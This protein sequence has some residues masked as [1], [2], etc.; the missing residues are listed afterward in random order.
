MMSSPFDLLTYSIFQLW[1]GFRLVIHCFHVC[2]ELYAA[3]DPLSV[4]YGITPAGYR[5]NRGERVRKRAPSKPE[6]SS[7]IAEKA[8]ESIDVDK[9]ENKAAHV[10][11]QS[12]EMFP[13][14]SCS[15][16]LPAVSEEADV[17]ELIARTAE[18]TDRNGLQLESTTELIIW[19]GSK[20][21]NTLGCRGWNRSDSEWE[22]RPENSSRRRDD[23]LIRCADDP[24]FRTRLCNHWD[25]SMGSS[26]P[27]RKKGKCIFAHGPVELRVK[28]GKRHRWGK[29][30]DKNGDTSNPKHSGGEDTYGAA[31]A[32]ESERKHEGKWKT[33]QAGASRGK[34]ATTPKKKTKRSS[35]AVSVIALGLFGLSLLTSASALRS[36]IQVC[37]N[38][39]CCQRWRH[40][41]PLPDV[42]A[43][44]L[45]DSVSVETTSCL[46]Q[47]GKGPNLCV[48][49][50]K[51][52][53]LQ[54][55][56]IDS[57]TIAAAVLEESLGQKIPS[58]L[59]AAVN[60]LEKAHKGK[61]C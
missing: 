3:D 51:G 6:P 60:V 5:S 16:G 49:N 54:L 30:V 52:E 32:I 42:L 61:F 36:T 50:S 55:Q 46:S 19:H 29:L 37:Q 22:R 1:N 43:D 9:G 23:A 11:E 17:E 56:R 2:Q 53:E 25:E 12:P 8:V 35:P 28:E 44:L 24:K 59:L 45:G 13:A 15:F 34:S 58:K 26:C 10:S 57:P 31:R 48:R 41:T 40:Q 38:K 4:K 33:N 27:M 47:C 18:A 7:G 20:A 14:G 21:A 39:D